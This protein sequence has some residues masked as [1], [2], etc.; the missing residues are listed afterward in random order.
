MNMSMPIDDVAAAF[1]RSYQLVVDQTELPSGELPVQGLTP[2]PHRPRRF[3]WAMAAVSAIVVLALGAVALITDAVPPADSQP[4]ERIAV[5]EAPPELGGE[6][7]VVNSELSSDG[8]DPAPQMDMWHWR[9]GE[10]P[11]EWVVLFEVAPNADLSS[12]LGTTETGEVPTPPEDG[13]VETVTLPDVGWLARSWVDSNMWRIVVGYDQA[14]VADLAALVDGVD[15]STVNMPGFE[16]VYEGP[17]TIYPPTGM[18]LS[19]LFY[20]SPAGGF[21]L[22]LFRG[23]AD[24][25]IASALRSPNIERTEVN[26]A[27]AVIAGDEVNW[28]ITWAIDDQS[29]AMIQSSDLGP[30]VLQAIAE[31]VRSVSEEEWDQI[32]NSDS[33]PPAGDSGPTAEVFTPV[34]EAVVLA[35]G[36]NWAVK[37]QAVTSNE[38]AAEPG[39]LGLCGWVESNGAV[40]VDFGCMMG[41]YGPSSPALVSTPEGSVLVAVLPEEVAEVRFEGQ[42]AAGVVIDPRI[43]YKWFAAAIPEGMTV[44]DITYWDQTGNEIPPRDGMSGS[45]SYIPGAEQPDDSG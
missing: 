8:F 16:L 38:D 13:Q 28:W 32:A 43:P 40:I 21:S 23:W 7:T 1:R 34:D 39:Q 3:G 27:E 2:P 6:P 24:G 19:E 10:G 44:G 22:H 25:T 11:T 35:A 29:T 17:Q 12:V 37:A 36:D 42:T 33:A 41:E 31:T 14:L 5:G 20:T 45:V 18:E 30:D 15:P 26:G 9:S 4:V